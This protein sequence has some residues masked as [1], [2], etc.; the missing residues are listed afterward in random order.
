[1]QLRHAALT[2]VGKTR[3]HNEDSYGI[4]P[5]NELATSGALFVVCDGIGGFE[6]GEVASELAVR[7][8]MRSVADRSGQPPDRLLRSAFRDANAAV[9]KQG[10]GKIGTTGVAALFGDTSVVLANVGDCRAYVVRDGQSR[11]ITR[12]HS[13]VAEQLAAGILTEAQARESSYRHVITRALGQ[14]P[15]VDVDMYHEP[16]RRD[17][18]VV[19]CSDGLHGQ[20][21]PDEIALAVT[22]VPLDEAC[23][24]LVRLANERG[25]PDNITVVA[26]RVDDIEAGQDVSGTPTARLEAA[27]I[28][29]ERGPTGTAR[30]RSSSTRAPSSVGGRRTRATSDAQDATPIRGAPRSF[31]LWMAGLL[32]LA[33]LLIGGY[34][35]FVAGIAGGFAPASISVPDGAPPT[36]TPPG[37]QPTV[38]LVPTPE[39]SS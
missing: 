22:R 24:A 14:R 11:Q 17:D 29:P 1:M 8:I 39:P 38:T 27:A 19:L 35:Y 7:T 9:L 2:D 16:L 37:E 21:E 5:G 23:R 3:D 32:L 10:R 36:Q 26:V 33:A 28:A 13:F 31:A 12:D 30:L 6:S 15:D 20:V 34:V 4:E 18:V 25:G